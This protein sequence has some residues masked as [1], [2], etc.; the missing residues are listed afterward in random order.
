MFELAGKAVNS[1]GKALSHLLCNFGIFF[2]ECWLFVVN[3]KISCLARMLGSVSA[4]F[5]MSLMVF[6]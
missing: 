5:R 4:V 2:I 6:G 1:L 3:L